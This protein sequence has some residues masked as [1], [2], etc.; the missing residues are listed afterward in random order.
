M[1]PDI[2]LKRLAKAIFED[3]RDEVLD[4]IKTLMNWAKKGGTFSIKQR[5]LFNDLQR[6]WKFRNRNHE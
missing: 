6:E 5:L 1:D 2:C 4:A 3:D